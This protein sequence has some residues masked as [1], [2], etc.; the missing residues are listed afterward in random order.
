MY[1]TFDDPYCYEGS[2]VLKNRRGIRDQAELEKFETFQVA[3]RSDERLPSGLLS[4]RHYRSIHRHLFQDVYSWAGRIRTVRMGK[5]SSEFCYP[6]Y[7]D[8]EMKRLFESLAGMNHLRDL[9]GENFA[10]NAAHFPAELNAIHPFREGNGRAQNVLLNILAYR[11]GHPLE[12]MRLDKDTFM[13][14]MIRSFDGDEV[15]L[16]DQIRSLMRTS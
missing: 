10:S 9:T 8:R 5:E 16:A 7:I 1:E 3:Q 2:S 4:Y 11:A 12:L 14:A 13:Q 6:E 15:P